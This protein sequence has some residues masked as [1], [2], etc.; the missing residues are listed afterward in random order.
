MKLITDQLDVHF[1][2]QTPTANDQTGLHCMNL[3]NYLQ[4]NVLY[5]MQ[6]ILEYFKY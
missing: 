1:S 2:R 4:N 6:N 3:L 5:D